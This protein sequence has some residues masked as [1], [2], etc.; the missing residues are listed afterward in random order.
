MRGLREEK[1]LL[2]SY[3]LRF[4]RLTLLI[5]IFISGAAAAY[6]Q[7]T[8]PS[9][10][11]ASDLRS[12]LQPP[13]KP[14]ET[15]LNGLWVGELLQNEG[16]IADKFEFSMQLYQNGIFMKGTAHVRFG[17]IWAEMRLSGFQLQ[18]GSWKLTEIEIL[19]SQKPDDLSWCMKK[20]E[21]RV[22]YTN[23]GISL[24]GPWWGNSGFGPCIPG[25]VRLKMKKKSA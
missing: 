20:Y 19:R 5:L 17:E 21:L 22:S 7:E 15:D 16:G 24:H 9:T 2:F 23:D 4:M 8:L 13:V 6:G 11:S 18:N 3:Y 14:L 1:R 10:T 12:R 25:S